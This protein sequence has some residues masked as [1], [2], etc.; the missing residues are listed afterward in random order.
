MGNTHVTIY[1]IRISGKT[2]HFISLHCSLRYNLLMWLIA[3]S[4]EY[5]YKLF[6]IACHL[7]ALN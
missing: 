1:E 6:K 7:L 4:L 2:L 5:K 3:S